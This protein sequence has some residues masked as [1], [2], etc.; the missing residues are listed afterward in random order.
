M[1]ILK[2]TPNDDNLKTTK[3]K[4]KWMVNS[5]VNNIKNKVNNVSNTLL[6]EPDDEVAMNWV[7]VRR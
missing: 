1:T 7:I 4:S 6:D 3:T 2:G 5:A